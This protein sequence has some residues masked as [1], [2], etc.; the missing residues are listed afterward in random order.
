MVKNLI[1]VDL[2][3]SFS[4]VVYLATFNALHIHQGTMKRKGIFDRCSNVINS[5]NQA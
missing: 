4:A 5:S 3:F 2:Y 1:F